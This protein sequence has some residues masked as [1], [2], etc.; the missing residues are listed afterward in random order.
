MTYK[1]PETKEFLGIWVSY[2]EK[3]N[4]PIPENQ[5]RLNPGGMS[6]SPIL[7]IVKELDK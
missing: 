3:S 7:K 6:L 4:I 2:F 1:D 5:S